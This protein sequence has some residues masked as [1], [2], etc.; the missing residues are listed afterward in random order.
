MTVS[1]LKIVSK[2]WRYTRSRRLFQPTMGNAESSESKPSEPALKNYLPLKY[3]A[4]FETLFRDAWMLMLRRWTWQ[5]VPVSAEV[6]NTV[7]A[8]VTDYNAWAERFNV[9]VETSNRDQVQYDMDHRKRDLRVMATMVL[10]IQTKKQLADAVE[11]ITSGYHDSSYTSRHGWGSPFWWN[12]VSGWHAIL[13]G[14]ISVLEGLVERDRPSLQEWFWLGKVEDPSEEAY[15]ANI[16]FLW[17]VLA[18]R[19]TLPDGAPVVPM[20]RLVEVIVR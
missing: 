14:P 17:D 7:A 1:E 5:S 2:P 18:L 6:I 11:S 10:V 19:R 16:K 8:W 12:R 20:S 3:G 15:H 9:D 13:C 4:A